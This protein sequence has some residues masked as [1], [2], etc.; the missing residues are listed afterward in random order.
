MGNPARGVRRG[1]AVEGQTPHFSTFAL[2]APCMLIG[3]GSDFPLSGCPVF[4]PRI[5]TSAPVSLDLT[6]ASITVRVMSQAQASGGLVAFSVEGLQASTQYYLYRDGDVSPSPLLSDA[7]GVVRFDVDVARRHL[8]LLTSRR[9][10]L[11][12]SSRTCVPP[13]GVFDAATSTC[14]L[15][16]DLPSGLVSIAEAGFT[17]DCRDP[18]SG[19]RH[20]IG[21]L[22]S[23]TT[24]SSG[25]VVF[26]RGNVRV[27]DCDVFNADFGIHLSS[28][29]GFE[30]SSVRLS[31]PDVLPR[32]TVG[33]AFTA[34]HSPGVRLSRMEVSNY[35]AGITGINLPNF[36]VEHGSFAAAL[37]LM[38]SL[39]ACL[40]S[41]AYASLV[42]TSD[43]VVFDD[44][45]VDGSPAA[46]ADVKGNAALIFHNNPSA[47]V[48]HSVVA[49]AEAYAVGI[50]ARIPDAGTA[51]LSA[52]R[53]EGALIGVH[54]DGDR[55]TV[56]DSTLTANGV[57]LSLAGFGH[58]VSHN[59][60]FGNRNT[61]VRATQALELSDV[62]ARQGGFWGRTCPGPLF[63][64]GVDSNRLDVVDSHAYASASAWTSGASP[65]CAVVAPVI[66]RPASFSFLRD[67][68][69]TLEGTSTSGATVQLKEG[70]TILAST[71]A[72]G[73]SF[74]VRLPQPLSDGPHELTA[75]ALL[76][77]VSSPPSAA[78]RFVI[79]TVA[80]G[81][82]VIT[83]PEAG[84]TLPAGPVTV[85][86][87]AE[88]EA[89]V[90]VYDGAT[91]VAEGHA[92]ADGSFEVTFTA[93][94]G[95][96]LLS[97]SAED[98]AGNASAHS[99]TVAV[100]LVQ[101]SQQQPL[102][103][104]NAQMLLTRFTQS[105]NSF[106]PARGESSHL[107]VAGFMTHS[108]GKGIGVAY[109]LEIQ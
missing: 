20:T 78:V 90:R 40:T 77:G 41:A 22:V 97:A 49:G 82:P 96:R 107:D 54:I 52:S 108:T 98:L 85:L 25:L 57:G 58:A 86:G 106:V 59:N 18:S 87:H 70:S 71:T 8:L 93:A 29:S 104:V 95:E 45:A 4:Q 15:T 19:A 33:Q 105:P 100:T 92:R 17:L 36:R 28:A 48:E 21:P 102:S 43:G 99:A 1:G 73:G 74:S 89:L 91:A 7:L 3:E 67:A 83:F 50:S 6:A 44:L 56:T 26:D 51:L 109:Q 68:R 5:R 61:Q 16:S 62:I 42:F 75:Q 23:G 34:S 81:P 88:P 103:G 79:D 46:A 76:G 72:T 94:A 84:T 63:V 10:S 47:T 12:L 66:L 39:Q 60:I 32:G 14:R 80:P 2:V 27:R 31:G 53:V 38:C 37:S 69:P 101:I 64:P 11:A 35:A 13:V 30:A 65:G 9:S 24:V 55:S